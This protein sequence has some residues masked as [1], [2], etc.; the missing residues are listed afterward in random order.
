MQRSMLVAST[1]VFLPMTKYEIAQKINVSHQAVYKWFNG[2]S[3]PSTKHLMA[4]SK[5]LGKSPQ[6]LIKGF[7]KANDIKQ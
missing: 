7:S 5:L 1:G 2:H 4:L 6:A 3:L